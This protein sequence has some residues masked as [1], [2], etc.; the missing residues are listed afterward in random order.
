[1]AV[2]A[3]SLVGAEV[4]RFKLMRLIGKGGMGR[5]YEG[6]HSEIG[7]RVAVKVIAEQYAS[8]ADHAERFFAEARAVNMIRHDGIVNIFDLD[9][10]PDGRPVIV[11]EFVEGQTLRQVMAAG[12]LPL[13]GLCVALVQVL[14]ALHAAHE[15][16]I[17]H[18]DLKP[19]NIMITPSG[20][21]KVLDFGIAKLLLVPAGQQAPRTRTGTVL[22]TPEYMAPEQIDEGIADART[23]VYAMG[24][25]MFEAITGRRPFDGP[26]DYAI[27]RAQ[28][29]TPPPSLRAMR[30]DVPAAL[31]H[32]IMGALA[33]RPRDRFANAKAMANALRQ[34][35]R[36]LPE[37]QWRS[38]GANGFAVRLPTEP[39][40]TEPSPAESLPTAPRMMPVAEMETA[41]QT[42]RARDTNMDVAADALRSAHYTA[43]V[44]RMQPA[45]AEQQ[46]AAT[47]PSRPPAVREATHPTRATKRPLVFAVLGIASVVAIVAIVFAVT[48]PPPAQ[49]RA[50]VATTPAVTVDAAVDLT[51]APDGPDFL[52]SPTPDAAAQIATPPSDRKTEKRGGSATER[53]AKTQPTPTAAPDPAPQ[54]NDEDLD[55]HAT[56]A[57]Q[58]AT[59]PAA[60]KAS[61]GPYHGPIPDKYRNNS[62]IEIDPDDYYVTA[63]RVKIFKPMPDLSKL[64]VIR[65]VATAKQ[66]ARKFEVDAEL[67]EIHI[68][69]NR[70]RTQRRGP[71]YYFKS[72]D[73]TASADTGR[74]WCIAVIVDRDDNRVEVGHRTSSNCEKEK[75]VRAPTCSLAA[76]LSRVPEPY[77]NDPYYTLIYREAKWLV[78]HHSNGAIVH[79]ID[80]DC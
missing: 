57:E 61:S 12:R 8:D 60:K 14:E 46:N 36:E 15:I 53:R 16:G 70:D 33:K 45:A 29:E 68:L 79:K 2:T 23:D 37:D 25:V 39:V 52:P 6:V 75:P 13:G 26:S 18:R 19:D 54:G 43:D 27:M 38:L 21:T 69:V 73:A 34:A 24:I 72:K 74:L 4:R 30:G 42:P 20:R 47:R 7:S 71:F 50:Q 64:D 22:G 59:K 35:S 31:E 49:P 17:V 62:E 65:Y 32:V 66:L 48:R 41:K 76:L 67:T 10:L 63:S 11:M 3:D 77:N 40:L 28:V 5:V 1:M 80:D 55:K 56:V 44:V 58:P 9:R 78:S 51:D